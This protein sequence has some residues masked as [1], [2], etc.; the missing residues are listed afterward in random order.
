MHRV[1]RR[2]GQP[3]IETFENENV[4]ITR[5]LNGE[6]ETEFKPN[7]DPKVK[8]T[9]KQLHGGVKCRKSRCRI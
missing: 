3:V 6:T 2:C 9:Y 4:K 8:E 7:C 5:F 1:T